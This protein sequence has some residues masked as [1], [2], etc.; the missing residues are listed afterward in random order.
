MQAKVKNA[1]RPSAAAEARDCEGWLMVVD[2]SHCETTQ[3]GLCPPTAR[4]PE[5]VKSHKKQNNAEM[6]NE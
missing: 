6:C 5:V 1:A 3:L 4:E 2:K